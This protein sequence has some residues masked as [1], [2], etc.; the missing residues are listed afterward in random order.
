VAEKQQDTTK[1]NFTVFSPQIWPVG[2][3]AIYPLRFILPF[4]RF[5]FVQAHAHIN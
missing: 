1:L 2:F 5:Q 3:D 4:V